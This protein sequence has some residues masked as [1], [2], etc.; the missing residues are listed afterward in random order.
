MLYTAVIVEPRKHK[1]L[2]FVL[3]NFLTNLS[4]DWSIIIFHGTENMEYVKDILTSL[5]DHVGRVTL[6]NLNVS[7][8]TRE[9]YSRLLT[10]KE[11]HN[12][13]PTEMFLIFQTDTIIFH[14]NKHLI[15]NFLNY[16]YVGAPWLPWCQ[17][18]PYQVG[19]GGL[20]LRK[21]SKMLQIIETVPYHGQPED[22]Y[23]CGT[24][25]LHTPSF[26][27][28]KTFAIENI[29]NP[30]SFGCHQPWGRGFTGNLFKLYPEVID[31]F[32]L[33]DKID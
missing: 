26:E 33:N 25:L 16:D 15:N 27:E 9:E 14:K 31:L 21:K 4:D 12:K 13:I 11:F 7:N 1:A 30:I 3:H 20:S 22:I 6:V 32:I 29:F 17:V 10:T 2:K 19:N 24:G 5:P 18:G 28:A 23:F 8:L